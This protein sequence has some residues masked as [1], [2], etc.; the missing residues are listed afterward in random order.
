VGRPVGLGVG[1][2]TLNLKP[3][4]QMAIEIK[5]GSLIMKK[6]VGG[7]PDW[8]TMQGMVSTGPSLT[9]A[10]EEEH[11]AEMARDDARV[12]TVADSWAILAWIRNEGPAARGRD[13]PQLADAGDVGLT[14][15]GSMRARFTAYSCGNMV[16]KWPRSF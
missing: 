5:G 2:E 4:T 12:S 3:G 9:A 11:R 15:S 1:I 6:V 13:L 10:L 14:M 7:F 16:R 8:R